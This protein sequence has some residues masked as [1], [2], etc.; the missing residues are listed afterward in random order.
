MPAAPPAAAIACQPGQYARAI[1]A[2]E[3][4][5]H[6]A[7]S[8]AR[9]IFGNGTGDLLT[10]TDELVVNAVRHARQTASITVGFQPVPGGVLVEVADGESESGR[11][12]VIVA[13]L[14]TRWGWRP[15]KQG[16]VVFAVVPVTEEGR[17]P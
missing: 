14:S 12:L 15:E 8:F 13:G 11:G 2:D 3:N 9:R 17:E 4:A 6:A 1:V 16:K 10:V 7:R 5:W